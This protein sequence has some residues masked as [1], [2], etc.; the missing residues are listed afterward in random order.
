MIALLP[1]NLTAETTTPPPTEVE[2]TAPVAAEPTLT[3]DQVMALVENR[4][5]G[6][7][8]TA[9]M[10]MVLEFAKA[11]TKKRQLAMFRKKTDN[12]NQKLFIHFLSPA[13]I[14]NTTYLVLEEDRNKKKWIYLSSF[15]KR[16]KIV[17]KD[18]SSSFVNSDFTYEDLEAIH[19]DEYTCSQLT[20]VELMGEPCWTFTAVKKD[21]ETTGYSKSVFTVSKESHIPLQIL[22]YDQKSGKHCKTAT[23]VDIKKIDGIW[24]PDSTIMEDH[25]NGSKTTMKIKEIKYNIPLDEATFTTRNMEK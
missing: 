21:Q 5:I 4:E 20:N 22:L 2:K 12:D 25:V 13:D 8:S 11:A 6:K 24:T 18:N 1:F 3:A 9:D 17:S 16:R 14:N 15:R 7:T 19:A 23:A 10:E